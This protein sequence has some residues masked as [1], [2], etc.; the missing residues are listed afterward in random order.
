[1]VAAEECDCLPDELGGPCYLSHFSIYRAA[2]QEIGADT[3]SIDAPRRQ[4]SCRP[5][6]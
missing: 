6:F 1:L 5:C 2:M 4:E 3:R